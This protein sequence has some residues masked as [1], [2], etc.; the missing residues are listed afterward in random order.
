MDKILL[1]TDGSKHSL[2]AAFYARKFLERN[3]QS[4]LTI[5]HVND[6]PAELMAHGYLME[7]TIDPQVIK[8]LMEEKHES[9]LQD[10]KAVFEGGDFKIDTLLQMGNPVEVICE[11]V[12]KEGYDLVIIGSRGMGELKGLLLGSVSD[13]VSHLAKCPVLIIK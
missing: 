8:V 11:L 12:A 10:T 1:P 2:K 4:T 6:I 9:L 13:R 3:P 7:V 5:L